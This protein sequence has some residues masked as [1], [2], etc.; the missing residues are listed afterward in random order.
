MTDF[1]LSK[2][3]EVNEKE[4]HY[5]FCGTPQYLAPELILK[6]GYNHMVDWWGLGILLYEIVVGLPPY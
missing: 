4:L 6:S 2:E 5:T 3:F 1:G